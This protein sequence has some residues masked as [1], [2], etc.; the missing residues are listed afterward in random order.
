MKIIGT[1]SGGGQMI[2]GGKTGKMV[3]EQR[4]KRG[5]NRGEGV[6]IGVARIEKT[7]EEGAG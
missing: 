4:G 1:R 6:R 3:S 5:I 2:K 7:M